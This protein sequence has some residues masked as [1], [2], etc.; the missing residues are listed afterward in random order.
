M[1]DKD[2]NLLWFGNY[3]G[4]GR[5]KEETKVTDS[6]YQPFRLQ[7]QYADH[8]T[9]LYY[10]FF[11]YYKPDA[12]RF[13]NQDPIGLLGGE[14]LCAFALDIQRLI[15]PL[16][17]SSVGECNDP[18]SRQ[19]KARMRHYTNTKGINGIREANNIAASDQ[20]LVFAVTKKEMKKYTRK[21]YMKILNK[22][23][24]MEIYLLM[25]KLNEIFHDPT[26]SEDI[27]VIKKFGDTYYPTIH[28]LYYKT[29]WNALTIEQRKEILG[30]DFTYENYGKYD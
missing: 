29:L 20:N 2:G 5:L 23:D 17:L 7:N 25:D 4:W 3:T 30:E 12:G 22:E 10:N 6:A 19:P 27:N 15:D 26:R 21:K 11:R 18:C 24:I 13:V 9:G 8:E 14:N 28:K 1:T 16:G